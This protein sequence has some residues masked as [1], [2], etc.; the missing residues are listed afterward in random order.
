MLTLCLWLFQNKFTMPLLYILGF[1]SIKINKVR[2]TLVI[3]WM[4]LNPYIIRKITD[5]GTLSV[6]KIESKLSGKFIKSRK[7]QIYLNLAESLICLKGHV[8]SPKRLCALFLLFWNGSLVEGSVL[9]GRYFSTTRNSLN[10]F[11][12]RMG[13]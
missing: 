13:L 7:C 11:R 8:N 10:A 5:Q 3:I 12:V 9:I 6:S 1:R 2:T 4:R